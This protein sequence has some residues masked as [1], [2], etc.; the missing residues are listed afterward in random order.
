MNWL[1]FTIIALL[2]WFP[3]VGLASGAVR[4]VLTMAGVAGGVVLAGVLHGRLAED[5]SVFTSDPRAARI[6]A[7]ASIFFSLVLFSHILVYVIRGI[8]RMLALGWLDRFGGLVVGL[9]KGVVI[10]E[11]GLIL[12][13]RYPVQSIT[14]AIHRSLLA[15]LFL[16]GI[17]FI[18]AVL[19]GDF[20][21]AVRGLGL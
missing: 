17:P 10:I 12:F 5:Y 20:R 13:S 21:E 11:M 6:A 19:P 15:P 9:V 16:D 7:F 4:E 2:L 3:L 14:T 1:D 8:I 18:L